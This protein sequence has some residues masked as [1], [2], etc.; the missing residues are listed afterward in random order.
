MNE[1]F[2]HEENEPVEQADASE[3]EMR[4]RRIVNP[5]DAMVEK[6]FELEK[7]CFPP[8]MLEP[9]EEDITPED[10]LKAVLETQ[11][12]HVLIE[13]KTGIFGHISAVDHNTECDFLKDYD[14]DYKPKDKALYV[15]CLDVMQGRNNLQGLGRP[16]ALEMLWAEFVK[17]AVASDYKTVTM[18]ARK[19]NSESDIIQKKLGG[20]FFRTMKNW[21]DMGED[22]DYLEVDLPEK[23]Q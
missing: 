17:E 16:K 19:S 4:V 23:E 20:K 6:I 21:L 5:D 3:P 18:Y 2:R 10:E 14:P 22:F 7:A 8:E 1:T 11:G 13:D 15:N 12:V 9:S